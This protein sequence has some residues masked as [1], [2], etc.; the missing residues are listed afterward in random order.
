MEIFSESTPSSTYKIMFLLE[1]SQNL[2][3][4]SKNAPR[5]IFLIFFPNFFLKHIISTFRM[6]FLNLIVGLCQKI[7]K[8]QFG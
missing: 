6:E 4:I 1:N 5:V 2:Y 8:N 3:Y 7:E